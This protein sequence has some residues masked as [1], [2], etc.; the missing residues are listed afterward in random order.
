M[1]IYV[2]GPMTGLPGLNFAAFDVAAAR[3]RADG[4]EVFNPAEL[5]MGS[6]EDYRKALTICLTWVCEHAE[7]IALLPGW[8]NSKGAQAE[9][10]AALALGL[11]VLFLS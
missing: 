7:A 4:H 5:G 1:K 6:A 9:Y 11:S 3:L 2:A 8:E 10:Y